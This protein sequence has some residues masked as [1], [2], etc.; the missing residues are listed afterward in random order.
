MNN[1]VYNFILNRTPLD[2]IHEGDN[3]LV[4]VIFYSAVFTV[5]FVEL[6]YICPTYALCI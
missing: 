2:I 6:Y 1:P 3:K 5:H 4:N